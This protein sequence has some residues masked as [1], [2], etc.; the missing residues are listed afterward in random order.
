MRLGG[1][2][3]S[4]DASANGRPIDRALKHEWRRRLETQ[5]AATLILLTVAFFT[6][7]AVTCFSVYHFALDRSAVHFYSDPK[8]TAQS[9]QH[10]VVCPTADSDTF[11]SVFN[12]QPQSARLRII[13]KRKPVA[14]R[15]LALR[16]FCEQVRSS[17]YSAIM[18]DRSDG[19]DSRLPSWDAVTFDVSLDLTPF[20]G[21]DGRFASDEDAAALE[22]HLHAP[23]PL[24]V[25]LFCKQVEWPGWEDIATNVRQRLRALGFAGVVEVRLEAT[26]EVLVFRNLPWQNF[27]RSRI[28]QGLV[29]LSVVGAIFWYP[30]L[31]MRSRTVRVESRFRMSLDLA[32]YWGHLS[33]GLHATEG[34]RV[35]AQS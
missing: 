13:G 24:E 2:T 20:V 1:G 32:Q 12:S 31:W 5:D 21:S 27:V 3:G 10:R 30:Y 7:V 23:N 18:S 29:L 17:C 26:E 35:H 14:S 6:T 4:V 22:R 15:G 11:M 16:E 19:R 34:F 8:L 9:F 25:L 28:T 33:E